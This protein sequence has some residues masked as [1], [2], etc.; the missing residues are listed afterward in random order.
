M[1]VMASGTD[2]QTAV[3]AQ[4][5]AALGGA[6]ARQ[7]GAARVESGD[8]ELAWMKIACAQAR[9]SPP[10]ETAYCVGCVLVKDGKVVDPC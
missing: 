3:L 7:N 9:L 1:D 10:V 6:T 8:T 2:R 4:S 5:A